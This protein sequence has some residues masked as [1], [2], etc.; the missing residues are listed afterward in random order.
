MGDQSLEV[1]LLTDWALRHGRCPLPDRVNAHL[2]LRLI[3]FA[4][5]VL[6]EDDTEAT[7][8]AIVTRYAEL[9]D[10]ARSAPE[11]LPSA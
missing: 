8:Q 1:R 2:R 7:V 4:Q 3:E 6:N 9:I 11:L 10:Q 5:E